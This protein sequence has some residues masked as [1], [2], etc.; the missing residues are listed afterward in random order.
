M[1]KVNESISP[2][3]IIICLIIVLIIAAFF[4]LYKLDENPRY[5]DIDEA[6]GGLKAE[7]ALTTGDFQF[8]YSI[9]PMVM[10]REP[11]T[12]E[13]LYVNLIALSFALF[14]KSIWAIRVTSAVI[15]LLTVLGIFLLSREI[16]QA[17]PRPPTQQ[18]KTLLYGI[19]PNTAALACAFL[20]AVSFWHTLF[21]RIGFNAT[22]TPLPTVFAFWFL[23]RA[24]CRSGRIRDFI[25]GGIFLGLSFHTYLSNRVLPFVALALLLLWL[26][27]RAR[28]NSETDK[29][30]KPIVPIF[31]YWTAWLVVASPIFYYFLTHPEDFTHRAKDLSIFEKPGW[32]LVV[33]KNFFVTLGQFNL[34]GDEFLRHNLP[35][36]PQLYWTTGIFFIIGIVLGVRMSVAYI[37]GILSKRCAGDGSFLPLFLLLWL[38]ATLAPAFLSSGPH[39]HAHRALNAVLPAFIL[40]ALGGTYLYGCLKR[41][42]SNETGKRLLAVFAI[43]TLVFTGVMEYRKYF[44]S[45]AGHEDIGFYFS[46][47][48]YRISEFINSQPREMKKF[49]IVNFYGPQPVQF[50]TD[51]YLEEGREEKNLIYLVPDQP[52]NI[53]FSKERPYVVIPLSRDKAL[54]EKM[55]ANVPG[56]F[57]QTE[58]FDYIINE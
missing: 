3:R 2:G 8:F 16:F 56:D 36:S 54:Y 30:Y 33:I 43:A 49:V 53:D 15:G 45:W 26:L 35:G 58:D 24:T 51:T 22:L 11:F 42:F 41:S 21:S 9:D 12:H 23:V 31:F 1:S 34:R 38:L 10:K 37:R 18:D 28:G 20:L 47:N 32:A 27:Q 17:W 13:G 5:L 46:K 44:Q 7:K 25:L 55:R 29:V 50:L 39:P 40:A 6:V 48:Q 57:V 19:N 14:G 52:I 4:R